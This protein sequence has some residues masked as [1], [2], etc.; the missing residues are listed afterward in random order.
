M[1]TIVFLC[2][3]NAAR[4]Q[5]AE[6]L[7]RTR[8]P[9]EWRVFS[10]GSNPA[11]RVSQRA[12]AVMNEIGIDISWSQPK[13][14]DEVPVAEADIVVTLCG[15]EVCPIVPGN[16][17]KVHWPLKDPAAATGTESE[18]LQVFRDTRDEIDRR[19]V[20]L[21]AEPRTVREARDGGK[22]IGS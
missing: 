14:M 2:V 22:L 1:P 20:G 12:I 19:L 18:Q 4:S 11:K 3:A 21:W 16:V 10:A 6:G 13:G 9:R 5:M 17:R 7:A 8:A 15:E